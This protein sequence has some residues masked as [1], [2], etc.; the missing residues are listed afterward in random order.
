MPGTHAATCDRVGIFEV[1]F[2]YNVVLIL[3]KVFIFE[4]IFTFLV[5]FLVDFIFEDIFIFEIQK[6]TLQ[7]QFWIQEMTLW[8]RGTKLVLN[9]HH[10]VLNCDL[11][12][13]CLV[14]EKLIWAG[15]ALETGP[16]NYLI[17]LDYLIY[18][19]VHFIYT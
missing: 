7:I 14:F 11:I 1:V 18:F 10:L 2:I 17:H 9:T 12:V 5:Y 19:S 13:I 3:Q 4:V 8:A 16:S 6:L 15:S